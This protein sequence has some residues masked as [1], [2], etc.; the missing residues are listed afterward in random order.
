MKVDRRKFL[1]CVL[2]PVPVMLGACSDNAMRYGNTIGLWKDNTHHYQENVDSVLISEDGGMLVF[3]GPDY[4]YIFEAPPALVGVLRTPG[5]HGR[6]KGDLGTFTVDREGKITGRVSL[7][8][9]DADD[10]DP[11][12]VD[13][14]KALGFEQAYG[15]WRYSGQLRGTR[16]AANGFRLPAG[17][18]EGG[19]AL[20]HSYAVDVIE[21]ESGLRTAGKVLATPVAV[22]ADGVIVVGAAAASIVLIP[23]VAVFLTVFIIMIRHDNHS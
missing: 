4:H 7:G 14:L 10:G 16:Y 12:L 9:E 20:S 6:I 3:L 1:A 22:G 17:T 23:V 18:K 15:R 21:P 13:Q 5:L 19:L 2:A 8:C 11:A